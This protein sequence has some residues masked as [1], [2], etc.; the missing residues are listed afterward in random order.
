MGEP[1]GTILSTA[2]MMFI[3]ADGSEQGAAVPIASNYCAASVTAVMLRLS[4]RRA[5]WT[6]T[7][8]AGRGEQHL[9]DGERAA[10]HR[11]Y[12]NRAWAGMQIV[13]A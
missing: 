7:L 1:D 5:S 11:P 9:R 10:T 2:S 12:F 4:Q 13:V 3:L 6:I 8:P